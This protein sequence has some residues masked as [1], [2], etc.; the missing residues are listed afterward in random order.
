RTSPSPPT[1]TPRR[2]ATSRSP[3]RRACASAGRR[4]R[5]RS[6]ADGEEVQRAREVLALTQR[7]V[8]LGDRR[9]EAVV[10]RLG[11]AQRLVHRVPLEVLQREGV[12]AELA[13]V[14]EAEDL[15]V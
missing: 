6:P 12:Q 1:A 15:H 4:R 9:G 3:R 10:E 8:L 14:V 2:R 7:E 11:D 13:R 5:D